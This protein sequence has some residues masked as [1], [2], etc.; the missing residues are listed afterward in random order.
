ME[1][2]RALDF[3]YTNYPDDQIKRIILSGGGANIEEFRKLLASES[4]AVVDILDP[5]QKFT[6][7]QKTFEPGYVQQIAP[8]AAI[9]MG[10]A[11]RR[12]DDK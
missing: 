10:L 12:V 4:S 3:F 6:L 11:M 1:I 5:F 8:Q 7:D 2:R 9:A